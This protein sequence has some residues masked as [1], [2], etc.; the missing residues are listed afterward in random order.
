M[1]WERNPQHQAM[2]NAMSM[3]DNSTI[4]SAVEVITYKLRPA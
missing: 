3:E 2:S 4:H 1:T